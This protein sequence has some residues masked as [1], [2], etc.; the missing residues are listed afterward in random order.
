MNKTEILSQGGAGSPVPSSLCEAKAVCTEPGTPRILQVALLSR[1]SNSCG[2]KDKIIQDLPELIWFY[3][4]RPDFLQFGLQ[5]LD[6]TSDPRQ[7]A[8]RESEKEV[9]SRFPPYCPEFLE[10]SFRC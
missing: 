4:E 8:A 5:A 7:E 2:F 6:D 10:D 9:T 3:R 1:F